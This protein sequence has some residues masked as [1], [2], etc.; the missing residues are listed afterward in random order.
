MGRNLMRTILQHVFIFFFRGET[1]K[2]NQISTALAIM[3]EEV[4]MNAS[5]QVTRL[6]INQEGITGCNNVFQMCGVQPFEV[7][8]IISEKVSKIIE[9]LC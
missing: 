5:G 7:L 9:E 6:V 8:K 1:R 3:I 4:E 2:R